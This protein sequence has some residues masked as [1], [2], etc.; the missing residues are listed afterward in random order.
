MDHSALTLRIGELVQMTSEERFVAGIDT[1]F[2]SCNV[3]LTFSLE[4]FDKRPIQAW[5]DAPMIPAGNLLD[6]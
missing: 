2:P 6:K 5:P 4:T 3:F 1:L